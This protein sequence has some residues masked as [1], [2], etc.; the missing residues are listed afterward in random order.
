MAKDVYDMTDEELEAAFLEAKGNLS[1][2]MQEFQDE[3]EEQE[4]FAQDGDDNIEPTEQPDESDSANNG[5]NDAEEG[6]AAEA[7]QKSDETTEEQTEEAKTTEET[8]PQDVPDSYKIKANGQEFD[9]KLSELIQLAPKAI[10]YTKKMQEIA[11]YRR[12]ISALKE[13]NIEQTDV[14]LLI[15]VLKGNKDAIAS[16]I[17]RTG[18]D[19]LELDTETDVV[20]TPKNYGRDETELAVQDIIDRYKDDTDFNI[21]ADVVANR[22]DQATKDKFFKDPVLIEKLHVDVKNGDFKPVFA[23]AQKLKALDGARLTDFDYYIQAGKSYHNAKEYNAYQQQVLAQRAQDNIKAEAA[24]IVQA[25]TQELQRTV[26]KNEAAVRK[27]A[28]PTKTRA[29]RTVIDY[30]D[31][32]EENFDNWLANL[33][34]NH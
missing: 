24:K 6:D 30:L 2:G 25:Q 23:E 10:D 16:I 5:D 11:P 26:T 9:F 33:K 29:A 15:D 12:I 31:E 22:F 1:S 14:N 34:N 7:S 20:Y 21:T 32:S 13:N 4:E 8:K 19:A 18:V 17:K 3:D 28:A 27:A